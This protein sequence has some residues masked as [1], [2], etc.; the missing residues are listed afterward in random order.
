MTI[1]VEM[2]NRPGIRS[3]HLIFHE[4]IKTYSVRFALFCREQARLNNKLVVKKSREDPL[5]LCEIAHGYVT[6]K[7]VDLILKISKQPSSVHYLQKR[8]NV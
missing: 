8:D 2:G 1:D 7:L 6:T 4:R 3:L 5:V